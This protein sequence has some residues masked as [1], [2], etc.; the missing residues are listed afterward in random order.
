MAGN[1]W[2]T[3]G[4]NWKGK[5]RRSKTAVSFCRAVERLL[6]NAKEAKRLGDFHFHRQKMQT[7]STDEASLKLGALSASKSGIGMEDEG[8]SAMAVDANSSLNSIE[9][10]RRVY[11]VF[12]HKAVGLVKWIDASLLYIEAFYRMECC[13]DAKAVIRGWKSVVTFV[14]EILNLIELELLAISIE[15]GRNE[16]GLEEKAGRLDS[17]NGEIDLIASI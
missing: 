6:E 11:S 2:Q 17:N 15:M 9:T 5:T 8:S 10:E 13:E 14:S 4:K 1:R 3:I 16:E 12:T 7:D